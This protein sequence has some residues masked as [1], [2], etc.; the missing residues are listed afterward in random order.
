MVKYFVHI[1]P[2]WTGH[3]PAYAQ[4]IWKRALRNGYHIVNLTDNIDAAERFVNSETGLSQEPIFHQRID[5]E[6]FFPN[7]SGSHRLRSANHWRNLGIALDELENNKKGAKIYF[8]Q[9]ADLFTDSFLEPSFIQNSIRRPWSCVCI[10]P[11]EF[12]VRKSLKRRIYEGVLLKFQHGFFFESRMRCLRVP[13]LKSIY[14]PDE[15]IV[16]TARSFFGSKIVCKKFPEISLP[17]TGNFPRNQKLEEFKKRGIPVMGI[18][19]VMQKR[20]GYLQ[21]LEAARGFESQWGFL[22]AGKISFD[23]LSPDETQYIR[24][25]LHT[26]PSNVCFINETLSDSNLNA[27]LRQCDMVSVAYRD[28]YHSANLQIK[29]AQFQIPVLAGPRHLSSER[30]QKFQLGVNMPGLDATDIIAT[31]SKIGMEELRK[32][33][34]KAHFASFV[35]EHDQSHLD[36]I[37]SEVENLQDPQ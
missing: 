25:V 21:M 12:R 14:F 24:G 3:I 4:I 20:K 17:Q 34:T 32:L 19:G 29:A 5:G 8:H 16:P 7:P 22:F 30:N 2:F 27:L 23:E 13:Q 28:F 18:L 10:H 37:F 26:P 31:L 11:V 1:N 15:N 9:W 35:Q 6:N 33:R 36:A